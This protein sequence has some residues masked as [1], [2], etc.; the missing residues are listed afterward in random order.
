MSELKKEKERIVSIDWLKDNYQHH[1][2]M[3][4]VKIFTE[5]LKQEKLK[6]QL[7]YQM[8]EFEGAIKPRPQKR[9][10]RLDE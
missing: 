2:S 3:Q 6:E 8:R 1:P 9:A 7:F 5:K 4:R 10:S